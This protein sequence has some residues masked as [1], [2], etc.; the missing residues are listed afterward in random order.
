METNKGYPGFDH[1]PGELCY[2]KVEGKLVSIYWNDGNVVKHEPEDLES[3][4][5]WLLAN[6]IKDIEDGSIYNGFLL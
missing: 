3:F 1:A 2:F 6:G 5:L 4:C